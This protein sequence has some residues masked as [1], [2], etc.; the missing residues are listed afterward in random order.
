MVATAK[1]PPPGQHESE[2]TGPE[3]P[4]LGVV[5]TPAKASMD[6]T[7][8]TGIVSQ[9][10]THLQAEMGI[11]E[12]TRGRYVNL[13]R[14]LL[15]RC[16][17]DPESLFLPVD[18]A[19]PHLDRRVVETYLNTLKA[20]RH[21]KPMSEAYYITALS[22]FFRFLQSRHHISVNPCAEMR[23]RLDGTLETPPQDT[24]EAVLRLFD[25]PSDTV[26]RARTAL[27]L[28]LL[29]GAGLKPSQVY[30]AS[31]VEADPPKGIVRV[32]TG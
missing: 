32:Q 9:Y 6:R 3:N 27:L 11:R 30:S 29:Y 15:A 26:D 19:F 2:S 14:G 7:T 18:W 21:W 13:A 16:S 28:E 4:R 20:E 10:A 8:L 24:A 23:P 12:G 22:A 5:L 17:A 25:A 1:S 31:A